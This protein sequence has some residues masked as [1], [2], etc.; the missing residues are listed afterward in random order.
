MHTMRALAVMVKCGTVQ[1]GAS[2]RVKAIGPIL[3]SGW[4]PGRDRVNR[5]KAPGLVCAGP[6]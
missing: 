6:G 1:H 2:S 4:H 3:A 5:A